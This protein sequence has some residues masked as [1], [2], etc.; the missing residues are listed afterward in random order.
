VGS[1]REDLHLQQERAIEALDGLFAHG[2]VFAAIRRIEDG[3]K[4]RYVIR[5]SCDHARAIGLTELAKRQL[6]SAFF[7]QVDKDE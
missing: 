5:W 6:F 1:V 7:S 3:G 4:D 2:F